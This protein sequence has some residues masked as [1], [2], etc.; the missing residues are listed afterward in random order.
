MRFQPRFQQIPYR[1]RLRDARQVNYPHSSQPFSYESDLLVYNRRN[2][3]DKPVE[4]TLS[5]NHVFQTWDGY[6]FYL[7][8][9][10][11]PTETAVQR[12]QLIVNHDPAKYLLTYPGGILLAM[13]ILLLF[14]LQP[15]RKK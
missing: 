5:M 11:P 7:A 13:G 4:T 15:Y 6:R 12:I 8:N 9:I 2:R 1:V 10:S 3:K 14:W